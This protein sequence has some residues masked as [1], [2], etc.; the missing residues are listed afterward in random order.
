[1]TIQVQAEGFYR[2]KITEFGLKE[3]Q[4]G[5]VAISLK[6]KL[7]ECWQNEEWV[8]WGR[9]DQEAEGDVWI[10]KKDGMT[11]DGAVE[12][13]AKWAGWDG[14]IESIIKATWQ[15]LHCQVQIKSEE[16]LG[17]TRCKIAFINDWNRLPKAM[18]NVT[19]ERAMQLQEKFG[20]GLR[21]IA[22]QHVTSTPAPAGA[23]AGPALDDIPF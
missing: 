6:A 18:T 16:Y 23:S 10:I 12:S 1:M 4:T 3:M 11:N 13:L 7:L 8:D 15:P 19:N 14:D 22:G 5:A 21:Y 20:K 17:K 2:V 9:F